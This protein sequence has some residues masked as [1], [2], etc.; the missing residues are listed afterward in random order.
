MSDA[1]AVIL[2][3]GQG[4]RM[5]SKRPKVLHP[6]CGR[7]MLHMVVDTV[8]RAGVGRVIVVVGHQADEVRAACAGLDLE[9]VVQQPQLGTG[10]AVAQAEPLLSR[11]DGPVLITYGDTPL[12]RSE[13]LARLLNRHRETGAAASIISAVVEDPTGYGRVVR[14]GATGRF[15]RV[16]EQKD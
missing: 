14:D 15:V 7:P 8:R 2:A 13:T 1:V 3:A 16:V 9:F 5:R 4:T 12:W 6:L 10:H 11:H